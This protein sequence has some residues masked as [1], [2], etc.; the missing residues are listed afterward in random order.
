MQVIIKG[1]NDHV[2]KELKSPV[3]KGLNDHVVKE[4]KSPVIKGLNDHVVK[5]LK[6]P[7]IK[8]LIDLFMISRFGS[9]RVRNIV[10]WVRAD[11]Y[12]R[13]AQE[14]PVLPLQRLTGLEH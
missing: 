8:G 12:G 13:A 2:V 7:V 10:L 1:L 9:R 6:S 11:G 5:E 3:I 14:T 4:L